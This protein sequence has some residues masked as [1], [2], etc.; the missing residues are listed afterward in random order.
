MAKKFT[1]LHGD[2][3]P[4]FLNKT[5]P[6]KIWI[7]REIRSI[8]L[9]VLKKSR[10]YLTMNFRLSINLQP[11]LKEQHFFG[12]YWTIQITLPCPSPWRIYKK[13]CGIIFQILRQWH[14]NIYISQHAWDAHFVPF[15]RYILILK[16]SRYYLTDLINTVH[17]MRSK[18]SRV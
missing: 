9:T 12:H 7:L 4:G 3:N 10:P 11:I 6:P 14:T 16:D 18:V 17:M 2:L 1:L 8:E 13:T 5:F 15:L